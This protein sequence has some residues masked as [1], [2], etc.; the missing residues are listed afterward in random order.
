V[1]KYTKTNKTVAKPVDALIVAPA[2]GVAAMDWPA[3]SLGDGTEYTIL[4][5]RATSFIIPIGTSSGVFQ[6]RYASATAYTWRATLTAKAGFTF[7]GI[8]A[9]DYFTKTATPAWTSITNGLPYENAAKED[10]I[11]ITIV[12]PA[13]ITQIPTNGRTIQGIAV[14]VT[15]GTPAAKPTFNA[16]QQGYYDLAA[17]TVA[18][19]YDNGGTDTPMPANTEFEGDTDYTAVI[20]LSVKPAYSTYGIST[21]AVAGATF[22]NPD[23]AS[24]VG[25]AVSVSNVANVI[26]IVYK[27]TEFKVTDPVTLTVANAGTPS[28]S[29]VSSAND[30]FSAVITWEDDDDP[31]NDF[32]GPF[33]T[34]G[35][36]TATITLTAED[37]FTFGGIAA[38]AF[39]VT[40]ADTVEHLKPTPGDAKTLVITAKWEL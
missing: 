39:T 26:T 13:T 27:A 32:A 25:N 33:V 1:F 4:A 36:Y 2:I 40:G 23:D 29:I 8:T 6:Y 24:I 5:P 3:V 10:C 7:K 12:F 21:Y 14:P 19:S 35:K 30:Q 17:T 20:T 34:G 37:G 15:G 31:G 9:T 38:N 22:D 28:T 16:T 11:D 18:W